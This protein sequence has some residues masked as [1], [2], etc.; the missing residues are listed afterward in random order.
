M[1]YPFLIRRK[2]VI[3]EL[4]RRQLDCLLVTHPPN[5]FYLTGFTGEA[6]LLAITPSG[7]TLI[8]DG[9]FTAQAHAECSDIRIELQKGALSGAAGEWLKQKRIAR[10]GYDPAQW[11]V[12][13]LKATRRAAGSKCRAVEAGGIVEGL[14]M[15]KDPQELAAM[16]KAA[17]LA[18]EVMEKAIRLLKP[19]VRESDIAAEIEYHMKRSGAS[20][21]SFETIVAS[22]KRAALP[23]ARPSSKRLKKNELVVLDLGAI[24]GHYC[25]DM[26]RTVF[27][28]RAPRRIR[29]WY[30]AVNEARMAAVAAVRE[31]VSAGQVDSAARDVLTKHGLDRYFVHSTGH[32]LGLEV[33]ED[34]RVGRGQA[35]R[36]EAGNVITIEPGVYV[37]DVGGIRIEDDVAVRSHGSEVLTRTSRDLIEL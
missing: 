1:N 19:G 4:R 27:L 33:H 21:A 9:R 16:R 8:T 10:A 15:R 3:S 5:W 22:G 28:G 14:R 17:I 34:P 31:G 30:R 6:G 7:A 26:T 24:L 12:A 23:H 29:E 35:I 11:T 32:G 36:L 18:N 25:S 13:Q 2:A 20:G 37:E